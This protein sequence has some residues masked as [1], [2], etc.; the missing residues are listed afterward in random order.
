LADVII[1]VPE[2][3]DAEQLNSYIYN[4]LLEKKLL[5]V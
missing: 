5:G 3:P 4:L 1:D 2:D